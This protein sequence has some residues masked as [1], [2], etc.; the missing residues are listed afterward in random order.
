MA[1]EEYKKYYEKKT[2]ESRIWELIK[3]ITENEKFDQL[4][5]ILADELVRRLHQKQQ[6]VNQIVYV[7]T[8]TPI[9]KKIYRK[10]S[11]KKMI[12]NCPFPW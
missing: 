3:K 12:H 11:E 2:R 9:I 1:S 10:R 8:Y 7:P 5:T 4:I 6:A